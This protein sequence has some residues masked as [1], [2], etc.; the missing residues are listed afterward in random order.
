M[1]PTLKPNVEKCGVGPECEARGWEFFNDSEFMSGRAE[2][3]NM[4]DRAIGNLE[5]IPEIA[6]LAW[7]PKRLH[8]G[9]RKFAP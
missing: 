5:L 8:Q 7:H 1:M 9:P 3:L 4:F 2:R 6:T